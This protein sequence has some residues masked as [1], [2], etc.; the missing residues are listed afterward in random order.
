MLGPEHPDTAQSLD[1]IAKLYQEGKYA[2]AELLQHRAL[3]IREKVLGPKHPIQL[4]A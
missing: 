2:K 4:A 3:V 1:N